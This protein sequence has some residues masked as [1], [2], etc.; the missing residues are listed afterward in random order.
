MTLFVITAQD[1]NSNRE[2]KLDYNTSD[3]SLRDSEG[4]R[5]GFSG[6]RTFK[7][8]VVFDK[9]NPVGKSRSLKTLKIQLGL[10]C[11][12]ECTYC[13]QRFVPRAAETNPD[14][15]K[16]FLDNIEKNLQLGD[17]T[18]VKVELWGG[19]PFVYWKTMKPLVEQLHEKYPK[20]TFSTITNGSLLTD[21]KVDWM[22]EMGFSFGMSHDGHAM[23]YRGP[24]PL[25]DP[26]TRRVILRAYKMFR[27]E[28]R[29]S[30]NA[31]MHGENTAREPIIN[32][33]KDFTGD[34][35]VIIGEGGL[36]D[37]Y[38][39][40]AAAISLITKKQQFEFRKTALKEF[41]GVPLFNWDNSK[42]VDKFIETIKGG[43]PFRAIAQKCGMDTTDNLAIDMKGN[44][45]T[46]QNVSTVSKNPAGTSHLA[47][48]IEDMESV[49]VSAAT[50]LSKRKECPTC[51]VVHVCQGSCM[52]LQGDLWKVSCDNAYSDAIG[53]WAYAI[54]KLT[55]FIPVWIEHESLPDYR[56]DIFGSMVEHKETKKKPFPIPVVTA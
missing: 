16:D 34:E 5:I 40:D 36:V 37:A 53:P 15:I 14:D 18:N 49:R 3:S 11:N 42:K 43:K 54:Y 27:P 19:E 23:K 10:S 1:P 13:S 4:N 32:F 7:D 17:G 28:Y 31:M 9:E 46:C 6:Q 20:M 2:I 12:Y 33:F 26:E 44:V 22:Y 24:D 50:H 30:F 51:P 21:D 8:A 35:S 25:D 52:F 41:M 39:D 56:K 45:L 48:N 29:M 55:G 47:G 38:D